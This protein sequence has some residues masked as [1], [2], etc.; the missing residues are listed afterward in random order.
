M[1][2]IGDIVLYNGVKARI[3]QILG[4]GIY[5]VEII[6]N[7]VLRVQIAKAIELELLTDEEEYERGM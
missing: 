4:N 2:N 1:Y 3:R 7:G 5:L 6:S